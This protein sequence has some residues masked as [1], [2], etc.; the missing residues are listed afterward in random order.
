MLRVRVLGELRADVDGAAVTPPASRRAW[1]LLAWLALHPGEHARG[2]VA[3]RF[4]PDVLD[5]SARASLRSALWELRRALGDGG[6]LL[7]GRDRIALR[8]E[9]DLGEFEAHVAAGRLEQ[10]VAL[11]RG[12]L[13]AGLDDDWALEA[14]DELAERLGSAYSRL[15][16]A[17]TTPAD[18]VAWARRRLQLDPLDEDAA[19]ELMRRQAAAGD[20]AAALATYDRLSDRLREAL[21]LAPSQQTRT[22]AGALRETEAPAAVR[23][24][25]VPLIG[26][27]AELDALAGLW[28]HVQAGGGAVAVVGGE[29]GI[30]KTRLAVEL[31]A[32]ARAGNARVGRC[33]AI[34]GAPPFAP[35]I[36]LLAGLAREL[37]PPPAESQWPEELGRLAPSLPR[38]LGRA[39][40]GPVDVPGELA[41]ARLFEAVV[42]LAEHATADRPLVLLFDDVHVADAPTL[43]LAAYLARRIEAMPVLIVLTRRMTPRR[44]EVDALAH[45]ARGR[46]VTVRELEL[47]PLRRAELEALVDAVSTLDAPARE[48]VIAAADG[49]PLLALESAR[50][51]AAGDRGPPA[52]LRGAVRAAIAG[53]AVPARQVA[54]L[55]AVAGRPLDRLEVSTLA[56]PEDV[57]ATMD[58]GLFH[59][60][61]GRF[62]FRHELLRE[63]VFADLEDV[64]RDLHHETLGRALRGSPAEAARHLRLAGRNDLAADRLVEAAAEAVRATALV[65]ATA[66]LAEAAELR[67]GDAAIRLELGDVLAQLGRRQ[68]AR[69]AL[70]QALALLDHADAGARAAAHRR[71]ALWFRGQLCDPGQARRSAQQGID[72]LDASVVD[73]LEVRAEL[74]LI[75]AWCEVTIDGSAA[76]DATLE[77][78]AAL[79]LDLEHPPLRRH[80]LRTVESFALIAGGRLAEAETAL[81]ASGEAG[82]AAGRPD[83]AYSGWANAACIAVA[84]GELGRALAHA[85]RGARIT[86]PFPAIALQTAGLRASVLALLGRH[87]EARVASDRQVELASRLG[88]PPLI[89]VADHDAGLFAALAGDHERAQELLGRALA[90]EPPVVRADARL[91]RAESLARLGRPEEAEAEIRAAAQE[92]MRAT[93]RPDVLVARMTFVQALVALARADAGLAHRRLCEAERHW[94][95]LARE[96]LFAR[97]HLASLVDLGRPP[98]TGI[99]D[100]SLELKR[101]AD[102]LR[103]LETLAD[104]R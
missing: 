58:C 55:A 39:R 16:A 49:N 35:W 103:G 29:G 60:A 71:A 95:R 78:L 45:A 40:G 76:A 31:L 23:L 11:H 69:A 67:P 59:S 84:S 86:G 98:V 68:P 100:P 43:E 19:R 63:A 54:E 90:G 102:E 64:R 92:P 30:G 80:H 37:A 104:V 50:A 3:A 22:L 53:L 93:H 87:A 14:R 94:R 13:L 81:V 52:S 82:E 42:E 21:G 65:E 85:E 10:A 44:D 96:D 99:V 48:R 36:E 33:S 6:A 88:A 97:E 47:Q 57:L 38:R 15:A 75:R 91:R 70:E 34:A 51:T 27:D 56:R 12:P 72:A 2:A 28:E 89:A 62:G 41:R 79:G 4:W 5:A 73:D 101:V 1:S 26:R 9:T 20:R 66:Y 83:L 74:L 46:G 77:Q 7:A 8:C 18:A 24:E 32:R 25:G 61:D 17:A